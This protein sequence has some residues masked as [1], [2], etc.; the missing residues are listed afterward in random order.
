[1]VEHFPKILFCCFP[2]TT[3]LSNVKSAWRLKGKHLA[4]TLSPKRTNKTSE[5][6]DSSSGSLCMDPIS[7]PER[8]SSERTDEGHLQESCASLGGEESHGAQGQDNTL[9]LDQASKENVEN[10]SQTDPSGEPGDTTVSV[11]TPST[12]T[13]HSN[14]SIVSDDTNFSEDYTRMTE[15]EGP[16][17]GVANSLDFASEDEAMSLDSDAASLETLEAPPEIEVGQYKELSK[18]V[19]QL[20]VCVSDSDSE[21]GPQS[22]TEQPSC[23]PEPAPSCLDTQPDSQNIKAPTQPGPQEGASGSNSD[24]GTGSLTEEHLTSAPGPLALSSDGAIADSKFSF[25]APQF[26]LLDISTDITPGS[27]YEDREFDFLQSE[28][29]RRT[30]SLKTYKTP[31]GTPHRKKAVRFADAL[32]LDLESVRHILNADAPPTIP[33]SATKH[34]N[35]QEQQNV[36]AFKFFS[37]EFNQP[38]GSC[39]FIQRVFSQKVVLENCLVNDRDFMAVGT[40]RVANIAFHKR[41]TVRYSFD[42]WKSHN[43][44]V[45]SYVPASNDGGTDRFAFSFHIPRNLPIGERVQFCV[46]YI[47]GGMT[48]WDNN[49][50]SNYSIQC[51]AKLTDSDDMWAH[52]L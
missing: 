37:V 34:L 16:S 23:V 31:P 33:S 9:K 27:T 11:T 30:T 47:T 41:V 12:V 39:G 28:P 36:D 45:G 52:F 50:G 17:S 15:V 4:K 19:Q 26:S 3:F 24:S 20:M 6:R 1:M 44:A 13:A 51:Y 38:G 10:A 42:S 14:V 7:S 48:F 25:S 46:C 43:D 2:R 21:T 8:D 5:Y 18:A 35:L 29:V 32:G 49:F 22:P 40:V